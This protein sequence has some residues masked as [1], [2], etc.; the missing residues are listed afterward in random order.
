LGVNDIE[1]RKDLDNTIV[2]SQLLNKGTGIP[3]S[4]GHG[5]P[6][7]EQAGPIL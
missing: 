5:V 4:S 7:S 2:S 3:W 6:A 1:L